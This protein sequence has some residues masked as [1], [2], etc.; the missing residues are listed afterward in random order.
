MPLIDL[1]VLKSRTLR[2]LLLSS[3]ISCPALVAPIV[4]LSTGSPFLP[5]LKLPLQR[6]REEAIPQTKLSFF[7][8]PSVLDGYLVAQS[9]VCLLLGYQCRF[10][11]SFIFYFEGRVLNAALVDNISASLRWPS[12]A[13]SS[14]PSPLSLTTIA[15]S[16]SPG[17]L[18]PT[19]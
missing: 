3:S 19:K 12:V 6:P 2:L 4:L 17:S 8:L 7:T 18:V 16:S 1:S 5:H 14:S 15:M 9:L 10:E 11:F 13:F